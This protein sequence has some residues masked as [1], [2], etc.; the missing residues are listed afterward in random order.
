VSINEEIWLPVV[1]IF[2]WHLCFYISGRRSEL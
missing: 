1:D 2:S